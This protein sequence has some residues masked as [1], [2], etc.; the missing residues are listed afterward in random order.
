MCQTS[1]LQSS[2]RAATY[3]F[4]C[5]ASWSRK[6]QT[7][8]SLMA[9]VK[10]FEDLPVPINPLVCRRNA[11][12]FSTPRFCQ[13]LEGLVQRRWAEFQASLGVRA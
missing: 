6:E 3:C 12:M 11:E 9:A 2:S 13:E 7:V 4:C 5:V 1:A 8:E 10:R